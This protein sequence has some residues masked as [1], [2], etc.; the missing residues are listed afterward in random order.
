MSR[1]TREP[2]EI[3]KERV[4]LAAI[5]LF[6]D[7]GA[8][9]VSVA[10]IAAEVGMS[11]QAVLYHYGTKASLQAAV[12]ERVLVITGEWLAHFTAPES[13]TVS[14]DG[15][16]NLLMSF[17]QD[18]PRVPTAILRELLRSP[19]ESEPRFQEAT[20]SWRSAISEAL[21]QGQQGGVIRPDL[22]VERWFDRVALMLLGSMSFPQRT[23]PLR[24]GDPVTEALRAELRESVRIGLV[25]AFVDPDPWLEGRGLETLGPS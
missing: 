16:T 25:S 2:P 3:V 22:D 19:D 21:R 7:R 12:T 8:D 10:Q 5:P 24:D 11:S 14:L 6:A 17:M 13:L 9:A 4:E 18:H 20:I 23:G 15:L 1:K